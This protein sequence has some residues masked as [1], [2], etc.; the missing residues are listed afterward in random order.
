MRGLVLPSLADIIDGVEEWFLN[1][2]KDKLGELKNNTSDGKYS[3]LRRL[4]LI[5]IENRVMKEA[6]IRR[7]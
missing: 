7:Y 6:M 3:N 4:S 5:N 2:L 1:Q